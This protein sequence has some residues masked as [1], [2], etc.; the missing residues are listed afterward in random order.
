[1]F[2][3]MQYLFAAETDEGECLGDAECETVHA[4]GCPGYSFT[5][6]GLPAS[7]ALSLPVLSEKERGGRA[8]EW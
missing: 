6:C 5:W 4:W 3:Q 8:G 2:K 1:M 7:G